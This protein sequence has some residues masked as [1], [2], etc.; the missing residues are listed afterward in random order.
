MKANAKCQ[1]C[2]TE[3]ECISQA[4]AERD[5]VPMCGPHRDKYDKEA[6]AEL[7]PQ[8][9][10]EA[11]AQPIREHDHQLGPR[12]C[13]CGKKLH[14]LNRGT[15]CKECRL[16]GKLTM[17]VQKL[18]QESAKNLNLPPVSRVIGT[19]IYNP[20]EQ[21][22]RH[23]RAPQSQKAQFNPRSL[24]S[25]LAEAGWSTAVVKAEEY[26]RDGRGLCFDPQF[27]RVMDDVKQALGSDER[28]E[29]ILLVR[30]PKNQTAK[31]FRDY[32]ARRFRAADLLVSI[33]ASNRKNHVGISRVMADGKAV[34]LNG[35]RPSKSVPVQR[36][37][38]TA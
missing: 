20:K 37:A 14:G 15:Q 24:P 32:L 4:V 9:I 5:E 13:A 26:E 3:D 12:Y 38:A 6:R 31:A 33:A 25:Q 34:P 16:G 21:T 11:E 1:P 28:G 8:P 35:K 30:P 23:T 29:R 17:Q 18:E 22:V 2:W 19:T 10:R 36:M 7:E 27:Q